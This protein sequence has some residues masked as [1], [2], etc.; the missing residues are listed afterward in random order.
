VQSWLD[1]IGRLN[2]AEALLISALFMAVVA[3]WRRN[4]EHQ[5][6][7]E[8]NFALHRDLLLWF[9]K[10]GKTNVSEIQ[11]IFDESQDRK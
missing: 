1:T 8:A 10:G 7:L 6:E 2:P 3:L 9:L 5:K 4:T 11:K